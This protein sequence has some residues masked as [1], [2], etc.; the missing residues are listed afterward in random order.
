[1]PEGSNTFPCDMETN[2]ASSRC[3]KNY[4][5]RSCLLF[6]FRISSLSGFFVETPAPRLT[7]PEDERDHLKILLLLT[8]YEW[9][10]IVY[11]IPSSFLVF[12]DFS[13]S[14]LCRQGEQ[15]L[16][17]SSSFA[18]TREA[19]TKRKERSRR[20]IF[21]VDRRRSILTLERQQRKVFAWKQRTSNKKK[22]NE[23]QVEES[24][25]SV[26]LIPSPASR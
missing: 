23:R 14:L 2:N 9:E 26:I 25:G 22:K 16:N 6:P 12:V 21:F 13:E 11:Q 24:K 18:R 1:M 19:G 17:H 20:L 5:R 3:I 15:H 4:K 8:S 10:D 7:T